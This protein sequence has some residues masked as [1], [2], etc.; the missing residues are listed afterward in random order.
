M[1]TST[2]KIGLLSWTTSDVFRVADFVQNW[3]TLDARPG[4][5]ICTSTTRPTGWGA[6]Q[7]GQHIWETDTK[8]AW[9]WNGA[10]FERPYPK[11]KLGATSRTTDIAT[12]STNYVIAVQTSVTVPA[13][14]RDILVIAELPKVDSTAGVVMLALVRNSTLLTAWQAT[15]DTS[16][17]AANQPPG[18][19]FVFRDPAPTPGPHGYALQFAVPAAFPGTATLRATATSPIQISVAEI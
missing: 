3:N 9:V 1:P 11:G 8:L 19:P 2:P 10:A 18:A 4:I 6:P 14:G 5:F 12:T 13:G 16:T 17:V 15:G 7:S